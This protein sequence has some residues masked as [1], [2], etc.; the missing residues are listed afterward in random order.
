MSRR[1]WLQVVVYVLMLLVYA[2]TILDKLVTAYRRIKP[3][4]VEA[5]ASGPSPEARPRK[6]FSLVTAYL[7]AQEMVVIGT[8]GL[9]LNFLGL[10]VS[11]HVRSIL[12][13]DMTGTAVTALLLG[14][15]WGAVVGTLSNSFVNWFFF[16]EQPTYLIVLPWTLVNLAGGM[17]W[18]FMGRTNSFRRYIQSE[19][20]NKYHLSYLLKFG[21]LA[22]GLMSMVGTAVQAVLGGNTSV[23]FDPSLATAI[24]RLVVGLQQSLLSPLKGIFGIRMGEGLSWAFPVWLQNWLRFIPDKTISAAMALA[25]IRY[26]LPVFRR[27]LA[28]G[29]TEGKPPTDNWTGPVALGLVYIPSF[30]YFMHKYHS[31]WPFW[32]SPLVVAGCGLV[33][34][35]WRGPSYSEVTQARNRRL[36]TYSQ[37]FAGIGRGGTIH[38]RDD[39]GLW[40]GTAVASIF[41]LLA[42]PLLG[43]SI[44]DYYRI[45]LNFSF[46]VFGFFFAVQLIFIVTAQNL[47]ISRMHDD[48]VRAVLPAGSS[49]IS[50]T[51]EPS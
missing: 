36:E 3:H 27:Q 20:S 21:V 50:R 16:P 14:P 13:L 45:A 1:D 46:V 42:L 32:I 10:A 38:F 40:F 4:P 30:L 37:V 19:T 33:R 17:F 39:Y 31:F 48:C 35:L 18:G 8:V 29:G 24:G 44:S 9:I 22:A 15:W 47:G 41:F 28:L 12:Y 7:F 34:L 43:I 49:P 23:S 51:S 11:L 2:W 25:I 26:G 6:W 5:P